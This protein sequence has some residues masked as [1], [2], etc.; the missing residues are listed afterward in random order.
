MA[1]TSLCL[2]EINTCISFA[3]EAIELPFI[4]DENKYLALMYSV[5]AYCVL[6]D[7]KEVSYGCRWFN[8]D[9]V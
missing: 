4:S 5:E 7:Q 3:R 6:G 9:L 1:Y 8:I 2:G